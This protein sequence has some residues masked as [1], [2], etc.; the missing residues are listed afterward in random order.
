VAGVH[1]VR[2]QPVLGAIAHPVGVEVATRFLDRSNQLD[3]GL[4]L[5]TELGLVPGLKEKAHR[6]NPFVEVAV[7]KDRTSAGHILH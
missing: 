3:I 6:F 2:K 4:G 5:R 1:G 7:G